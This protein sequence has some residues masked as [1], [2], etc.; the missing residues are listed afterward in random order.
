MKT[1]LAAESAVVARAREIYHSREPVGGAY[2]GDQKDYD[3]GWI[4]RLDKILQYIEGGE[5]NISEVMARLRHFW[6]G[7]RWQ[8]GELADF[9][10]HG[11]EM[12][13]LARSGYVFYRNAVADAVNAMVR[14]DTVAVIEL[15]SGNSESTF[16]VWGEGRMR[17]QRFYACEFSEAGRRTA[18]MIASLDPRL[19]LEP[20]FF[21]YRAPDFS[22][23]SFD[24]GHVI[25]FST[26]SIEQVSEVP[27]ALIEK[28]CAVAPSVT[29]LHFE[30]I[31]W[32]FDDRPERAFVQAHKERCL[33]FNYNTNFWSM[34]NGLQD[35]GLITIDE[36]IPYL[37]GFTYNPACKIV[38]QKA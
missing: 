5:T 35:A 4:N 27:A 22:G 38:W 9:V 18:R 25:V 11:E 8:V 14:K 16:W 33:E 26:H 15:G 24:K 36:A 20:R 17:K 13:L 19:K 23:I 2:P 3:K 21:D 28:L 10:C 7:G 32:Q 12:K 29:G 37:C 30:P 6:M 1:S 34:L 31:G